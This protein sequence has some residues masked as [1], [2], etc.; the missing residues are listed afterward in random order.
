MVANDTALKSHRRY[1]R[2]GV[3]SLISFLAPPEMGFVY[4]SFASFNAIFESDEVPTGIELLD[5][6]GKA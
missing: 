5:I 3:V 6:L 1:L 2:I 4:R